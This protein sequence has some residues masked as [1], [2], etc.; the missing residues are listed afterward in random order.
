MAPTAQ[1]CCED[2]GKC[3]TRVFHWSLA[4]HRPRGGNSGGKGLSLQARLGV[5]V[6]VS[7]AGTRLSVLMC[8]VETARSHFT[9]FVWMDDFVP[10]TDELGDLH[11]V[12]TPQMSGV[13]IAAAAAVTRQG[14]DGGEAGKVPREQKVRPPC[15][16]VCRC[17][18]G[19]C[20]RGLLRVRASPW[21]CSRGL[22]SLGWWADLAEQKQLPSAPTL[23]QWDSV[24]H[25]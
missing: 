1:D 20:E 9:G 12:T 2:S 18:P 7:S 17:R 21:P 10:Q 25:Q 11:V 19:T 3:G 23:G 6:C 13:A 15:S 4:Q 8:N 14:W 22:F 5:D 16:Q 24:H